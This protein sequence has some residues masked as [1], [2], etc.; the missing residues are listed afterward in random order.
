MWRLEILLGLRR[1]IFTIG[2][3]SG[4]RSSGEKIRWTGISKTENSHLRLLLIEAAR[5]ICKDVV[6]HK[7]KELCSRQNGNPAVAIAEILYEQRQLYYSD[8]NEYGEEE[9]VEF[10][11]GGRIVMKKKRFLILTLILTLLFS[12]NARGASYY[13]YHNVGLDYGKSSGSFY[14]VGKNRY[15]WVKITSIKGSKIRYRYAK[16]SYSEDVGHHIIKSYGKTY[17][18]TLTNNTKYYKSAPWTRLSNMKAF[19][20][21]YHS[22][23][24]KKLK[25]LVQSNK[26]NTFG[27]YYQNSAF[28]IKTLKG[29]VKTVISPVIFAI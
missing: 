7:S 15:K 22:K 4:E 14:G 6:G 18:A 20:Y 5:E 25:I 12:A 16:F 3:A 8:K 13:S 19:R 17:T 28:Y 29:K 10:R 27:P 2:L 9:K 26:R 24:F 21:S 1:V 23:A 11:R